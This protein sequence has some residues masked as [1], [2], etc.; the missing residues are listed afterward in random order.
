MK[1]FRKIRCKDTHSFY[2]RIIYRTPYYQ[3]KV[4][5]GGER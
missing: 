2:F 4:C 5:S 3:L 1:C